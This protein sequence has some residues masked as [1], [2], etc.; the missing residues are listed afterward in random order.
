M[1]IAFGYLDFGVFFESHGRKE[2]HVEKIP[3]SQLVAIDTEDRLQDL[4]KF[5]SRV[6]MK[7]VNL[8]TV[9]NLFIPKGYLRP[10]R[11]AM[12]QK[13]RAV[14]A[15]QPVNRMARNGHCG[16]K[17]INWQYRMSTLFCR[18]IVDVKR[19]QTH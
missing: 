14:Q 5:S 19:R 2:R 10:R 16:M 4:G 11:L 17:A 1:K 13:H 8:K 12:P 6:N 15:E 9:A 7:L 3:H 18:G